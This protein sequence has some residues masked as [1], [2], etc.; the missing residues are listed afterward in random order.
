MTLISDAIKDDHNDLR[1]AHKRIL[2]ANTHDEKVRWR[3]QFTWELARHS[4]GEELVVY[5]AMESHLD[6]GKARADHDRSEHQTVKEELVKFQDLDPK[7]P[8]FKTTLD[9]LWANLDKHMAEEEADDLPA[10]ERALPDYDAS[11]RLVRPFGRTKKFIPT[12][13]HPNAPDKPPFETVAGL[14]AAP[15][16]HIRDLFRKFPDETKTGE[17]PP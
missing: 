13:S 17:M 12:R 7:D 4:I 10:L 9:S 5:P 1:E 8:A 11:D 3:N 14:L 2:S 15:I 16:D 6:D